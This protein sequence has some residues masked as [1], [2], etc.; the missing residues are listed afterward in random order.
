MD[1]SN[2]MDFKS[3]ALGAVVGET[4]IPK[5]D[6]KEM[7]ATT[8]DKSVISTEEKLALCPTDN[9]ATHDVS[10]DMKAFHKRSLNWGGTLPG[11]MSK[12]NPQK[13]QIRIFVKTIT[14]N[15]L[16]ITTATSDTVECM[17]KKIQ[18]I[19]GIPPDQMR[20]ICRGKPIIDHVPLEQYNIGE[21]DTVHLALRLKGGGPPPRIIVD[22]DM[23]DPAY[24]YDFT[25]C[26]DKGKV[27][28]R[29]GWPYHRPY[30]WYRMALNVKKK[31]GGT[32][33]LGRSDLPRGRARKLSRIGEWPVS[34][35]GTKKNMAEAIAED[36]YD[37]SKGKRFR[38]GRGIYSTPHPDIAER[39][40][41]EFEFKGVK[42]KVILQNR[43]NMEDTK[44]IE[45][46]N[47]YVTTSEEN[48]RPYAVL[49]KKM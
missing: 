21:G 6:D 46:K 22:K 4:I 32:E 47:Y 20:L 37:L 18:D 11:Y 36:G 5:K 8:E 33:W 7:A 35:H 30:G 28:Q 27:Y 17:K 48:I 24:D 31:Y 2:N 43:V 10:F 26:R 40:A 23:W 39:Y 14:G 19:E 25:R 3:K 1:L 12:G 16:E 45:H 9:L 44:V 13:G 41:E 29:G 34:Y 38:Y 49:I 42:Y 15:T